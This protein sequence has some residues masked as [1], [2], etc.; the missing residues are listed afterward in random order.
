MSKYLQSSQLDDVASAVL[1]LA[2]E[3]WVTRDRQRALEAVLDARGIAVTELL[4]DYAPNP[5]AQR[6][7]D[8]ERDAFVR[9]IVEALVPTKSGE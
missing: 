6:A 9:G 1:T 8:A 3:L 5:D 2:K 7:L 4:R